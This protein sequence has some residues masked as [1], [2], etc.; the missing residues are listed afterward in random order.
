M[1]ASK[2]RSHP[3][4]GNCWILSRIRYGTSDIHVL[5]S[6]GL[7]TFTFIF[8]PVL[9]RDVIVTL[10]IC[11]F[12]IEQEYTLYQAGTSWPL[13]WPKGGYPGPQ[14][15]HPYWP[16]P[17]LKEQQYS[18]WNSGPLEGQEI[19]RTPPLLL[20]LTSGYD[21]L[22]LCAQLGVLGIHRMPQMQG[23]QDAFLP[24]PT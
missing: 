7:L 23:S 9:V 6:T 5:F 22:S 20:R 18:Y 2:D 3:S 11:R 12:G 14:V 21:L 16:R 13:G 8:A 10:L 4:A 19:R 15:T 17:G 24:R 1:R